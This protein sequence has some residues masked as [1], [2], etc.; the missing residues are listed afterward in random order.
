[1]V[2]LSCV[3]VDGTKRGCNVVEEEISQDGRED[4]VG[5]FRVEPT[6]YGGIGDTGVV[7]GC[8]DT[9]V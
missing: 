2:D 8:V 7:M 4:R 5:F 6:R 9:S 3:L 1:M